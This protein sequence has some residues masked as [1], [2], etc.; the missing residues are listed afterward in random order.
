MPWFNRLI[1]IFHNRKLDQDL[2]EELGSHLEMRAQAYIDAGMGEEQAWRE[3]GRKFGNA[4]LVHEHAR[5]AHMLIWLESVLQDTGYAL[6]TLRRSPAFTLV[7][8][9]SLAL[10]IGLNGA[11]FSL[12]DSLL[13]RRVKLVDTERLVT[14]YRVS[15]KGDTRGWF[16][17]PVIRHLREGNHVFAGVA[18]WTDSGFS[19]SINGQPPQMVRGGFYSYNY[20]ALLG[21]QPWLGRAFT[22]EDDQPGAAP[23]AMISYD[24]WQ[25]NFSASPE[26]LGRTIEIKGTPFQIIGVIPPGF[27]GLTVSKSANQLPKIALPM[28]W[29]QSLKLNDDSLSADVVARLKPGTPVEQ[30]TAEA[31]LI[32]HRIPSELLRPDWSEDLERGLLSDSIELHPRGKGDEWAWEDYKL[33][34]SLLMGAVGLVLLIACANVANLL[35]A[36]SSARR[37]EIAVRLAIGAARW[38]VVRQLLT[39][40]LLLAGIGG[41]LGIWLAV[42]AHRILARQLELAGDLTLDWRVLVFIAA[43]CLVAGAFF[44]LAPAF[45][46]TRFDL[47]PAIKGESHEVAN[48]GARGFGLGKSLVVCQVALSL[49]LIVGTGLLVQ[50]LRNL[51]R[52]DPGF[53]QQNVLLFWIYPGTAGYQ[54]SNEL[55][56]YDEYLRRFNSIPGVV[57]ASMARHYMMQRANNFVRISL[58]SGQGAQAPELL[59]AFN[60]VAPDFFSTMRIPLLAGRDFS[61]HDGATSAKVAI[62][63]QKFAISHFGGENPLGKRVLVYGGEGTTELEIVG[64]VRDA[65]FYAVREPADLPSQEVFVPYTQARTSMLGQMCFALRTAS[66]PL[67]VLSAVRLAAQAVDKNLPVAAPFTQAG[68]AEESIQEEHSLAI[69]TA[70]FSGMAM[71]LASIGLYGVMAYAVSRRTREIGV[72]MA[73][74]AAQSH[75]RGMFLRE[76]GLLVG[77]GIVAGT[78]V[79]LATNRFLGSLLYGVRPYDTASFLLAI[80]L[81]AAVAALAAYLPARRASRVDPMVALRN[82]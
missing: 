3:A 34:L 5:Q 12:I 52:V 47:S 45:R 4:T 37:R 51:A 30:A 11:V 36:R 15:A 41:V 56:L 20:Y 76:S 1:S 82:E 50:T 31:N 53:D 19:A 66:N 60:A 16:P 27:T 9:S 54:G 46:G 78:G 69:L 7:A 21:V 79:A 23:V 42:L 71:M 49:M 33:R 75:V 48:P 39:E 44:G 80:P 2:K 35:L 6:R 63:D 10:G 24:Y 18:A 26:V 81:L 29:F 64:I 74:G 32:L 43:I 73:L 22:A 72:R 38:R 62:V 59:A 70:S 28:S 57:K 17:F 8:V 67:G 14:V 68:V 40:S 55:R 65:R 13:F 61:A 25:D 77:A 58:A